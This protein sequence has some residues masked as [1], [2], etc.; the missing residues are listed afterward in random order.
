MSQTD[1]ID[2]AAIRHRMPFL[3]FASPHQA[4][5]ALSGTICAHV[6]QRAAA[7]PPFQVDGANDP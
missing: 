1:I 3:V 7:E 6:P 4:R 5:Y 2:D